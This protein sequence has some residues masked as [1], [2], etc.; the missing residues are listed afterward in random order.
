M[1]CPGTCCLVYFVRYVL[2]GYIL[3]G[4]FCPGIFCPGFFIRVYF[5][6][7]YFVWS[8]FNTRDVHDSTRQ[9][10]VQ[11]IYRHA[12]VIAG[13][14][15]SVFQQKRLK[16]TVWHSVYKTAYQRAIILQEIAKK[17]CLVWVFLQPKTLN[18]KSW[19]LMGRVPLRRWNVFVTAELLKERDRQR[20]PHR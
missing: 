20:S 14:S 13:S 3:C 18:L 11:R 10:R 2:S 7:V 1:F 17:C 9:Q 12:L 4:I 6:L 16:T 5:V 19:P 8:R 15:G